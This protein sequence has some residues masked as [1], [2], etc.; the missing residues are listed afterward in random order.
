MTRGRYEPP[1]ASSSTDDAA[2]GGVAPFAFKRATHGEILP[3]V[4]GEAAANSMP[5]TQAPSDEELAELRAAAQREGLAAG[6]ADA[7]RELAAMREA[8]LDD[9]RASLGELAS[10]RASMIESCR[11]ELSELAL[12][13]AEAV[14]QREIAEGRGGIEVFLGQALLEM[15]PH[16]RCTISIAESDAPNVVEWAAAAWPG[17]LV[18]ADPSLRAGELRVEAQTG[19]IEVSHAKRLERIRR[20]V[21]GGGEAP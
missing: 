21:L 17:A 1:S 13:I 9:A 6:R 11:A 2:P 14:V 5:P 3:W 20:L 10:V 19:N 8:F 7:Q 4:L 12:A 16:E 18:R 15:D